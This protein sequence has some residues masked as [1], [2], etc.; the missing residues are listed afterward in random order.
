MSSSEVQRTL[1][2]SPPELWAELGDPAALARHLGGLGEIRI[3]RIDPEQSVEWESEDASGTVLIKP[4]GW[5][6]KVTLTVTRKTPEP[7]ATPALAA[8]GTEDA[9]A[10]PVAEADHAGE[11]ESAVEPDPHRRSGAPPVARA[12]C[13]GRVHRGSRAAGASRVR[14]H[15]PTLSRL[16]RPLEAEPPVEADPAQ[17]AEP[18]PRAALRAGSRAPTSSRLLRPAVWSSPE[19]GGC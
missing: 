10:E 18:E 6:T 3:T 5:G 9:P 11:D 16:I 15:R 14:R 8:G 2:K 12:A 19:E 7:T 1:V 17:E 13:A 4:S